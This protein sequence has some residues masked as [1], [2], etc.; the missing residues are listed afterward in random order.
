MP[1]SIQKWIEAGY[2]LFAIDGPDGIQVEKLSRILGLNKSGFYHHFGDRE[3][4]FN[5]MIQH[6]YL[7]N[8]QFCD[9]ISVADNFIPGFINLAIKYKIPVLVQMQLRRHEDVPIFRVAFDTCKKRNLPYI[10]PLWA[11]YLGISDN[12]PLAAELYTIFQEIFFMRITPENLTFE[13]AERIAVHFLLVM[14]AV[15]RYGYK[16]NLSG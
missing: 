13:F 12:P 3:S 15:K 16:V 1:H 10:I 14:S 2:E 7:L 6:H 8:Q 4:F 5:L 11:D 9:G